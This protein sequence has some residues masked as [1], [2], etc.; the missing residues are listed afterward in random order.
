MRPSFKMPT[1]KEAD[2]EGL[3]SHLHI[4][5]GLLP[6]WLTLGGWLLALLCLAISLRTARSF[7]SH[8]ALARLGFVAALML[9]AMSIEWLA[10]H[11][12]LSVIAGILLGPFV[13]F[14]AAFL[15][16]LLLAL[17]GHGGITVVGL[18]ALL[19]GSEMMMGYGVF[20]GLRRL[21]MPSRVASA[22][23]T[24]IGLAVGTTLMLVIVRLS[25][26]NPHAFTE[27]RFESFTLFVYAIGSVGWIFEA[28][29][30]SEIVRYLAR[31]RPRMLTGDTW[32]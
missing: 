20:S 15:V 17:I 22:I 31:V 11:L 1:A 9:I 21:G 32:N 8:R 6:W 4:P 7:T 3:M 19:L 2:R 10:Y 27:R 30:T 26:L 18:N 24:L 25:G 28:A 14:L 23:A 12:N 16:D 29:V 5:D 13:G